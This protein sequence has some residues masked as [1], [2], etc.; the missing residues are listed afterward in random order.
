MGVKRLLIVVLGVPLA[1]T[2]YDPAARY[3]PVG[4]AL[5]DDGRVPV[6]LTANS[7]VD[8][9]GMTALVCCIEGQLTE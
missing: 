9:E 1:D 7:G 8:P 2:R 4:V 6:N 5:M 3:G